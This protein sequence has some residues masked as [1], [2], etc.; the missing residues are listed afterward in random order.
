MERS[1]HVERQVLFFF[2]AQIHLYIITLSF[3]PIKFMTKNRFQSIKGKLH[4]IEGKLSQ[5]PVLHANEKITQVES[6]VNQQTIS[7][8]ATYHVPR[9]YS[10]SPK[11]AAGAPGISP[12]SVPSLII[13][14]V[15][16][17]MLQNLR[18][19]AIGS[20]HQYSPLGCWCSAFVRNS[21]RTL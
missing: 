6:A 17:T 5:L 14:N 10:S 7:I 8:H 16:P 4:S 1:L 3:G 18:I 2:F 11:L 21:T 12:V 20:Q 13:Q 19:F 15:F 9:F